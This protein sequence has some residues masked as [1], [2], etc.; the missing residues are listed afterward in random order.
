MSDGSALRRRGGPI[1]AV[2]CS[3][4][5]PAGRSGQYGRR[6]RCHATGSR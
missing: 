2:G 5:T 3:T 4:A 6:S 1:P